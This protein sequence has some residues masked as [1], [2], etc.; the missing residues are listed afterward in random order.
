MRKMIMRM[1]LSDV[2]LLPLAVAFYLLVCTGVLIY[3]LLRF[4]L[5]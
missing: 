4:E 2:D 1:K 5:P 3:I